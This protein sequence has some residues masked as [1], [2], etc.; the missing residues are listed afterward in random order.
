MMLPRRHPTNLLRTREIEKS[1]L[2]LAKKLEGIHSKG[3]LEPK[4]RRL[5]DI[6]LNRSL[7]MSQ[8]EGNPLEEVDNMNLGGYSM[9]VTCLIGPALVSIIWKDLT[10]GRL[11]EKWSE[12]L[13]SQER[14]VRKIFFSSLKNTKSIAFEV[15]AEGV[16]TSR[17]LIISERRNRGCS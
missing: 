6:G 13:Q 11:L 16:G 14:I 10:T 4:V 15:T 7:H 17:L 5:P 9:E 8:R 3:V 1:N 2:I 12:K